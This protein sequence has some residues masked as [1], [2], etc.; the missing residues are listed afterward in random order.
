MMKK[1]PMNLLPDLGK[2]RNGDQD[3][4]KKVFKKFQS[5]LIGFA[6]NLIHNRPE[7]ED[8]VSGAFF[9]LWQKIED[10]D[11]IDYIRYFLYITVKYRCLDYIRIKHEHMAM[12]KEYIAHEQKKA[13]EQAKREIMRAEQWEDMMLAWKQLEGNDSRVFEL[14]VFHQKT[15]DEIA[16]EL[17]ISKGQAYNLYSEALK[18]IKEIVAAK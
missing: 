5:P 17:Q 2:L 1:L 4:Y 3:E 8:I 9:R 10:V 6:Y 11:T 15:Y 7:G 18:K 13:E 14:K 12:G 16:Q